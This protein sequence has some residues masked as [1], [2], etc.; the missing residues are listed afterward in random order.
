VFNAW[1]RER[2]PRVAIYGSAA[3]FA[4]IHE[5][6]QVVPIFVLGVFLGHVY[7]ATR[8]LPTTMALH[9]GFNAI[10]LTLVF[11]HRLGILDIPL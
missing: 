6:I 4:V 10:S 3:L 1:E 11:L 2:G 7:R 5:P 8:S 9:A